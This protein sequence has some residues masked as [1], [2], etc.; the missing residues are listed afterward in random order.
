MNFKSFL[1]QL[2]L[3][4]RRH[5]KKHLEILTNF[6]EGLFGFKSP[7]GTW[8]IALKDLEEH[9][10]TKYLEILEQQLIRHLLQAV[11]AGEEAKSLN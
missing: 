2:T 1:Q 11:Q 10:G 3:Q 9:F 6:K 7:S 4:T 8:N 5:G